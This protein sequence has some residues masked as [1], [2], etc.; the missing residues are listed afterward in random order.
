[1]KPLVER[2]TI[3]QK[4]DLLISLIIL[5]AILSTCYSIF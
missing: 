3:Q 2:L 1:M 4:I 5:Q